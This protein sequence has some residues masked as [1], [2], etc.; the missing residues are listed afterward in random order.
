MMALSVRQPWASLIA[1]GV[2]R[3]E[4]RPRP[5]RHRGPL[6]ICASRSWRA[7]A[8]GLAAV[9]RLGH[10]IA[11]LP[12]GVAIAVVD[13]VGCR[14]MAEGDAGAACCPLEPGAFVWLLTGARPIEPFAVH[15]RLGLFNVELP[16][17][18]PAG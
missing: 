9:Q 12:R 4:V 13:V 7:S 10:D 14:P 1:A 18:P 15:G 6:L 11:A 2:K 5:T 8:D 3:A 16:P 17:G